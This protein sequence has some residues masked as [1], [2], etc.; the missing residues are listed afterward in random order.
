ML[1]FVIV[2]ETIK[3]HIVYS[4]KLCHKSHKSIDCA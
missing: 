4:I 3:I 2:I 1:Q